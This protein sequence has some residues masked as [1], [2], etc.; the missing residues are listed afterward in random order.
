AADRAV[1]NAVGAAKQLEE[2]LALAESALSSLVGDAAV[3]DRTA[4]VIPALQHLAAG[5]VPPWLDRLRRHVALHA[6]AHALEGRI[7][8]ASSS[9]LRTAAKGQR[10][11]AERGVDL[12][13]FSVEI[14]VAEHVASRAG[15]NGLAAPQ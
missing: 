11:G 1:R 10:L 9:E 7:H 8:T 6:R 4:A 2:R 3:A 14:C 13:N 12:S 15:G 5:R